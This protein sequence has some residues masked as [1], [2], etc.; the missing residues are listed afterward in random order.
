MTTKVCPKCGST[1]LILL[2]SMHKKRCSVCGH[3]IKWGLDKGQKP[4][5]TSSKDNG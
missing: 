3:E 4:L 5:V 2:M 1:A